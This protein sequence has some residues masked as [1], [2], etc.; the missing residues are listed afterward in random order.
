MYVQSAPSNLYSASNDSPSASHTQQAHSG[1]HKRAV[2][3]HF[4]EKAIM[5]FEQM[6]SGLNTE[7][8]EKLVYELNNIGKAAAFASTNGYESQNERMVVSQYF[9]Q[10]G[11]VISDE[12][13]KKMIYTKLN[14]PAFENRAFFEEFAKALDKPLQRINITV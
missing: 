4:S 11:G 12:A 3:E 5:V 7:R 1:E 9:E 13:I 14:N 8:K 6:S 10:L 2:L